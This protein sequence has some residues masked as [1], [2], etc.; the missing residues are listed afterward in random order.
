MLS[1]AMLSTLVAIQWHLYAMIIPT[2][3]VFS[4]SQFSEIYTDDQDLDQQM[5]FDYACKLQPLKSLTS[6]K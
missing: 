6:R 2:S 3:V 5:F 1:D 4:I